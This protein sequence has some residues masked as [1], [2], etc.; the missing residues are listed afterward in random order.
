MTLDLPA[1][2]VAHFRA[3]TL[4]SERDASIRDVASIV[5]GDPGLT[6]AVIRAA[7]SAAYA[8]MSRIGSAS[9]AIVRVGLATTQR[10][11]ASAAVSRAFQNLYLSGLNPDELWSHT[12]AAAILADAS[13]GED[14]H[15]ADAFTAGLLLQVGRLAMAISQP[16]RYRR[17][18]ELVSRKLRPLD[19]ETE[20]FGFDSI[21]WGVQL[22]R[23]WDFPDGVVNA[24]RDQLTGHGSPLAAPVYQARC[25]A[26]ALGYGDGLEAPAEPTFDS[27][28]DDARILA[29]M[30]G[31][32][33]LRAQ[34]E[35][36][37]GALAAAA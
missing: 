2:P 37:R 33:G 24:I 11:V 19:A 31:E 8:P 15:R 23:A 13:A 7:N 27:E 4:L 28:S 35:W 6:A 21:E 22:T 12:V 10:I 34:I 5:E 32:N 1:L 17:V 26:R 20:V 16:E 9:Q 3:M 25:I 36:Y 18:V 14:P 29:P 30:G